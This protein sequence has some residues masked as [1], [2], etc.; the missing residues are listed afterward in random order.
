M[1][2]KTEPPTARRLRKA[3]EQGDSPV[4]AAF[5]T[6]VAFLVPLLLVPA[7]AAATAARATELVQTASEIHPVA[8]AAD[9][10]WDVAVLSLPI[11]AAAALGAAAA[12]LVQTQ[13]TVSLGRVGVRF[14]RLDPIEGV[15]NLFRMER[16]LAV[17]RALI[18][19]LVVALISWL[20]FRGHAADLSLA[21]GNDRAI[22]R[23]LGLTLA[24]ASTLVIFAFGAVDV[25]GTFRAWRER[26]KMSKDEVRREHREA[27]GDPEVRAQRRRAHQEAREADGEPGHA[28]RNERP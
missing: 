19:A 4:S 18:S 2:D 15:R 5:V 28:G 9:L 17:A 3:R 22:V 16:L 1:S 26:H 20:L 21:A 25:A 7:V 12:G 24:W 8:G 13:G 6:S 23:S 11:A 14:D 27:E 10:A